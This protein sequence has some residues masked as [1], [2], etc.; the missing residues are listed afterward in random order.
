MTERASRGDPA[1]DRMPRAHSTRFATSGSSRSCRWSRPRQ[2]LRRAAARATSARTVVLR[3]RAEVEAIL[4]GVDD[5]LLV[6]VGPCSV[7][8]L[9][10]AREYAQRLAATAGGAARRPVHRHARVLREA[11]HHHRLEGHDQRPPPRRLRGREHRPAHGP[12]AAARGA[13]AWACRWA[14][15]SSTRSPRSTSPT[16]WPGGRSARAPPRARSTA[17]SARDCRCPWASRT[18]PTATSRWRWTPCAPPRCRT[19][20]PAWTRPGRPAILYTKGNPDCHVILR[21]GRGAPNYRAEARWRTRSRS[22]ARRGL[23]E[24]VVIDASH[25]NSGKDHNRQPRGRGGPGEP[26]G[27]AATGRSSA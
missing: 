8:D 11:A 7:H 15:S 26:D 16:P 19:P 27:A 13:R 20:S 21:G 18:A 22:C 14:A 23:P 2:M 24:R 6:V 17:S 1:D 5:R 12:R 4:N 10:A 9:D 25:D 3:G